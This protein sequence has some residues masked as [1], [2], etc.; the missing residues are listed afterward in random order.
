MNKNLFTLPNGIRVI[1]QPSESEVAHFGLMINAGSRD[2]TSEQMGVAHF[3]EHTLFKGTRKRKAHHIL[4]R[5]EHVGGELNAYTS[6]EETCLHASFLKEHA[7]RAFEL[8]TD[9]AFNAIFPKE[10]IAKERTVIIDE[11]NSYKENPSELI[12]DEFEELLFRN[13]S[14]GWP[15]SGTVESVS[16]LNQK[17]IFNYIKSHYHPENIVFSSAGNLT[18]EEIH[19]LA[20]KYLNQR[21]SVNKSMTRTRFKNYKPFQKTVTKHIHQSHCIIG[22]IGYDVNHKNRVAMALLNNILGGPGMNS[23]LNMGIREKYGF[24]YHLESNY[25][26]FSDTGLFYIYAGTEKNKMEKAMEL[27]HRELKKFRDEKLSNLS[28]KQAKLQLCGQIAISY[29]NK[30]NLMLSAAKNIL[31]YNRNETFEQISKKINAIE[32]SQI[33]E[34]ANEILNPAKLST[35]IYLSS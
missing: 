21:K 6:K 34:V 12:F 10:E 1:H 4:T 26:A 20:E 2:E 31:T 3:I 25:H 7:E 28:L 15:I 18:I 33:Q 19:F 13:H 16:K 29:E 11:I 30:I 23:R 24:A 35:L 22:N 27:I 9:V 14:M 32:A 5:L 8:I 17:D